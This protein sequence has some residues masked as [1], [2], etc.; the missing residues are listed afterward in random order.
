MSEQD[1]SAPLVFVS[2]SHDS[3]EHKYWVGQLAAALRENGVD[4]IFDQWDVGLGDDLPKF[5]ERG[6]R[7]SDRVLMVCTENYVTKADEGKGGVGYEAMVVTGELIEDLG[8][9]KFIPVVR[10]PNDGFQLPRSVGTRLAVDFSDSSLFDEKLEELLRE[11]H[12]APRTPKPALG[13]NPFIETME[14]LVSS[15]EETTPSAA[16]EVYEH[17]ISIARSGDRVEWRR[18]VQRHQRTLHASLPQHWEKYSRTPPKTND[19]AAE[20]ML[21]IL[22]DY[23]THFAL[24]LA[25]IE[26]T[27]PRF[28]SQAGF[29]N[30]LIHPPS[31]QH[32][33]YTSVTGIP[34]SIGCIFNVL[35]G[36]LYLSTEQISLAASLARTPVAIGNSRDTIL[37]WKQHNLTAW[38]ESLGQNSSCTFRFFGRLW[39]K[40]G[41]LINPF[42]SE[43]E[44]QAGIGAYFMTMSLI[45]LAD[46]IS[47]GGEVGALTMEQTRIDIPPLFM[48]FS[49]D[50][51]R[52]AVDLVIAVPNS[53]API[54][55]ADGV[56]TAKIKEYWPYWMQLLVAWYRASNRESALFFEETSM[57]RIIESV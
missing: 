41:W 8:T 9:N 54:W 43:R 35:A 37:V 33:G 27:D 47:S 14:T 56:D 7:E 15:A 25:G 39:D 3:A 29:F 40:L 10:Q 38:P 46:F 17:A 22:S 36:A 55:E 32:G 31:W 51:Q 49:E 30:E 53:L 16:A 44:Y 20:M 19:E 21:D 52:R 24:P 2:Y 57:Q 23:E 26:S 34:A 6:V 18:L 42:P 28:C 11:I 45:E 4:V 13:Q 5:M 1:D 48:D 12:Q 50:V